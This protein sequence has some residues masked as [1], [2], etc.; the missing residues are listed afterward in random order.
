MSEMTPERHPLLFSLRS[1]NSSVVRVREARLPLA[2]TAG[3]RSPVKAR[4]VLH[5]SVLTDVLLSFL[6]PQVYNKIARQ[7]M[8]DI[9]ELQT[10]VDSGEACPALGE[11][12]DSICNQARTID[13]EG[14]RA[15]AAPCG[16]WPRRPLLLLLGVGRFNRPIRANC[17]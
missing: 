4:R 11:K 17:F 16:H 10:R 7:A 12:A 6:C 2:D 8:G 5:A 14:R 13:L 9:K 3:W 15:A 1:K